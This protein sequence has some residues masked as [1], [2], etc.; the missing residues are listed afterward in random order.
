MPDILVLGASRGIGREFVSQY[1][2]DGWRVFATARNEAD[3]EALATA[4]ADARAADITDEASLKVLAASVP[5]L[6]VVIVNAGVGSKTYE[7]SIADVDPEDWVRVMKVNALGPVLAARALVPRLK[8][9]GG[10]LVVLSSVMGSIGENE[11]GNAW[12]YR[13]SKAAANMA[14]RNLGIGLKPEGIAVAALHPGWVKTDIG[15]KSAPLEPA[16]SVRGMRSVIGALRPGDE[17][18]F[19]DYT[20]RGIGW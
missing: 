10:K 13:M 17:R 9:P 4:G 18:R 16:D 6:D 2:K 3:I 11:G 5:E 8:K 15:G 19:L 7:H 14:V 20:G 12:S 1:L